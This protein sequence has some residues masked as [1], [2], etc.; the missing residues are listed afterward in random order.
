MRQQEEWAVEWGLAE[1]HASRPEQDLRDRVFGA[2]VN[3]ATP[4]RHPAWRIWI[5]AAIVLLSP[6]LI[7][8][9]SRTG[10]AAWETKR[11]QL[12][13]QLAALL[14]PGVS[15]EPGRPDSVARLTLDVA[16][17]EPRALDYLRD[18][19]LAL[20]IPELRR[21]VAQQ[22]LEVLVHTPSKATQKVLGS[23]LI[24]DA[25]L[26][27]WEQVK[28]LGEQD[29]EPAL[30]VL[31]KKLLGN[32]QNPG[33]VYVAG[34]FA[35]RGDPVGKGVLLAVGTE[36]DSAHGVNAVFL[37][38]AAR[39]ALGETEPW[40]A[41]MRQARARALGQIS[42][43]K[44]DA[45]RTLLG[46][47]LYFDRIRHKIRVPIAY[48]SQEVATFSKQRVGGITSGKEL[49]RQFELLLIR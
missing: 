46:S 32:L 24:E 43:N 35:L 5:P 22:V 17:G 12:D 47:A 1:L 2:W 21:P 9:G 8:Y 49:A 29:A 33:G 3:S 44:I 48:L 34:L 13:T 23:L 41:L 7:W 16:A 11:Q 19:L 15:G 31:R 20:K 40:T 18:R 36:L 10:E 26:F 14:G 37:A 38:A 39:W 6:I 28:K 25:D 42:E 45:A 4:Q 27:S 30:Q